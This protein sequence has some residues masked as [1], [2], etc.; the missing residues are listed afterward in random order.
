MRAHPPVQ[1][2]FC[3]WGRSCS[4]TLYFVLRSTS[5]ES[6]SFI[7]PFS[8][9]SNSIPHLAT[10]LFLRGKVPTNI[11]PR[12]HCLVKLLHLYQPTAKLP[13]HMSKPTPCDEKMSEPALPSGP[14]R[15]S[16]GPKRVNTLD[17][18]RH[19]WKNNPRSGFL[20]PTWP[21]EPD[22]SVARKLAIAH[23]PA[24]TFQGADIAPFGRARFTASTASHLPSRLPCT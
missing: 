5:H 7:T 1:S 17:E 19:C 21:R 2:G 3:R 23:L 18:H 4:S 12:L 6:Y 15:A 14:Q 13:N 11:V 9:F 10:S 16:Q 22:M 24:D 20:D 8:S